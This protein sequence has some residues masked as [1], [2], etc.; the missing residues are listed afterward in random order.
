[1]GIERANR[2]WNAGTQ[3]EACGPFGAK[4]ARD[5]VRGFIAARKL[6]PHFA[7]QRIDGREEGIRG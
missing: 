1:M 4:Q 3:S 2:N 6:F 7:Q 5:V